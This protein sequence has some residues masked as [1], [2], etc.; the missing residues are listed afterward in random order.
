MVFGIK[1]R[2]FRK[3]RVTL[4]HHFP[5]Y[6]PFA[7]VNG[8]RKLSACAQHARPRQL[9]LPVESRKLCDNLRLDTSKDQP[10]TVVTDLRTFVDPHLSQYGF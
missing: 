7:A 5:D 10:E 6:T 3:I 8:R 2:Y 4:Q 9:S 1:K